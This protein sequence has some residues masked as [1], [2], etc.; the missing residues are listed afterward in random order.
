VFTL[1]YSL[2]LT[3]EQELYRKNSS[4]GHIS[5]VK[6]YENSSTSTLREH[7]TTAHNIICDDD[8]EAG[9][10][11][12]N[13][14]DGML[15]GQV[16]IAAKTLSNDSNSI[17]AVS[18]TKQMKLNFRQKLDNFESFASKYELGRD[19]VVW[20]ALDLEPFVFVNKSGTRFF[21]EKNVPAVSLPSRN[22]L[23]RT[24]LYDVS[25]TLRNKVKEEL[26]D[27]VEHSLCVMSDG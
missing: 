7:L 6:N 5:R 15:S 26:S 22:T 10:D 1:L 8:H 19:L 11:D 23:S 17:K 3:R 21:F 14:D 25:E 9:D 13:G 27:V 24:A 16:T 12:D 4:L 18:R 2:C 20:A